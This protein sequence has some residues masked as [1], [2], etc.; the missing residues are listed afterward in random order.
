MT[1][2]DGASRDYSVQSVQSILK[3]QLPVNQV[4]D[5]AGA[6]RLALIT[7]GG[8]F[9]CDALSYSDNVVVDRNPRGP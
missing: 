5:R 6:P 4:F 3:A 9:D 7:C 1:S 2:A 8:Q